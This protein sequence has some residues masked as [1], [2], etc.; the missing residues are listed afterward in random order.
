[1]LLIDPETPWAVQ[2]CRPEIFAVV[3]SML[4][5]KNQKMRVD[6]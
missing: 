2:F 5:A 6:G 3:G 1:M 4:G